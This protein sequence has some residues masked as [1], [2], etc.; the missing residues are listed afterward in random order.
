MHLTEQHK[1]WM[2]RLLITAGVLLALSLIISVLF[3]LWL[4]KKLPD[5]IRDKTPYAI[6]YQQLSVSVATGN[7]VADEIKI[8]PKSTGRNDEL[9]ITGTATRVS[10]SRLGLMDL[11]FRKRLNSK[12]IK[13]D[14]PDLRITLAA[15]K[16]DASN[17]KNDPFSLSNVVVNNGNIIIHRHTGELMFSVNHFFAEITNLKLTEESVRK[18]FP[19]LFDK[20]KI[21]GDNII[22]RPGNSYELSAKNVDTRDAKLSVKDFRYASL[23]PAPDYMAAY[24]DQANM[25]DFRSPEMTFDQIEVNREGRVRLKSIHFTRPQMT[26]THIQ[27]AKKDKGQD[28]FANKIEL[29]D[30]TVDNGKV[31]FTENGRQTAQFSGIDVK[32]SKLKI[33]STTARKA[34]PFE[35]DK[36]DVGAK[37][38]SYHVNKFYHLTT[39]NVKI[40]NEG[41]VIDNFKMKPTVSRA[42]FITM[43]PAERDLYDL[44]APQIRVSG[45]DW[46]LKNKQL[47]LKIKNVTLDR[48]TAL[49]FRSKVPPTDFTTKKMY[50]QM[51]REIK[52]PLY[53]NTLQ[54]KNSTVRYEEDKPDENGPGKIFFRQMNLQ[55]QNI[56]SPHFKET[57]KEVKINIDTRFMGSSPMHVNWNF[58][59][60]NRADAFHI[61]GN[62]QQLPAKD[63]NPFIRPYMNI[64]ATGKFDRLDFNLNGNKERID[65]KVKISV[66]DKDT[67]KRKG[68]VSG[69]ANL[70]IKNNNGPAQDA[71]D[72]GYDRVKYRSFFNLFWKAIEDGLKKTLLGSNQKDSGIDF[73]ESTH[74]DTQKQQAPTKKTNKSQKL[75]FN[76]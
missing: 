56:G 34:I 70:I 29:D 2:K 14:N 23:L 76:Q 69:L 49:I 42:Q 67:K 30:A 47:H 55:A 54:L 16:K 63:I 8:D 6:R 37:S 57:P 33:D 19:L 46:K 24:K 65:G 4:Q 52:F 48:L 22:F 45:T 3:N 21:K 7:I 64:T 43:I 27:D 74:A 50:S 71:V 9:G 25:Y 12:R 51:L 44:S 15:P 17:K 11:L 59:I 20:Y 13:I 35:F 39:G 5:L 1:K 73:K 58:N 31:I 26:I 41:A 36:Y 75:Q 66:L 32:L 28:E 53:I 72:V 10:V 61:A 62:F 18:R 38:I 68:F 40:D 60:M